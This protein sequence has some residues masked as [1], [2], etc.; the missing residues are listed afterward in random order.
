MGQYDFPRLTL[1][2]KINIFYKSTGVTAMKAYSVLLPLFFDLLGFWKNR[3]HAPDL[4]SDPTTPLRI[5]EISGLPSQQK[6]DCG[7]FVAA[8]VEFFIHEKD[9]PA[10]FDIEV[11]R[12]R[13]AALFFSY[14]QRKID[15][16][17][18]SDDE[19]QRKS[20]KASKL[21]K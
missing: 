5:V 15:E 14:G 16:S 1:V 18:D 12:T 10:D 7:A 21:K 19:K 20:S 2:N 9:V 4:G 11:Y 8:F 17:I 3:S 13:L 6:N